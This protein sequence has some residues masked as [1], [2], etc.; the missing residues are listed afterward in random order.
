MEFLIIE[1]IKKM[2]EIFSKGNEELAN[3]RDSVKINPDNY[4]KQA[5]EKRKGCCN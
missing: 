2:Q 1:I 3:G 4:N 5:D